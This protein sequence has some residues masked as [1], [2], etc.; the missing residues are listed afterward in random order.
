MN[1]PKITKL[2]KPKGRP[3]IREKLKRSNI[4]SERM[5]LTLTPKQK[6]GLKALSKKYENDMTGYL[7][8]LIN[9]QMKQNGI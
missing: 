5:I 4:Y 7:R 3:K 2:E 9:E 8:H 6:I 1:L